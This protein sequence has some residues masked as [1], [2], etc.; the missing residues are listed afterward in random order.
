M[1]KRL[2]GLNP[3][4]LLFPPILAAR[5]Q[6]AFTNFSCLVLYKL[7]LTSLRLKLYSAGLFADTQASKTFYLV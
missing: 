3:F 1:P 4:R 6:S 5:L 2:S 7:R